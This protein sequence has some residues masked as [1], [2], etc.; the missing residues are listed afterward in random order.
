MKENGSATGRSQE[1]NEIIGVPETVRLL[2]NGAVITV[3][4]SISNQRPDSIIAKRINAMI[5]V[6]VSNSL[7]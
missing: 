1:T 4:A 5:V 3:S 2:P 6:V 7:V